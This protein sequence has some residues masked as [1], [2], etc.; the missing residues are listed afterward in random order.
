[1][2]SLTSKVIYGQ[3]NLSLYTHAESGVVV[4]HTYTHSRLRFSPFIHL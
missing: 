1:M 4:Y 3:L 2:M